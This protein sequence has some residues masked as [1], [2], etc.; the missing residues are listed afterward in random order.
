MQMAK[1]FRQHR[2]RL[3]LRLNTCDILSELWGS[4]TDQKVC[5]RLFA[6][7]NKGFKR[8]KHV[9]KWD[10]SG[11]QV[12]T[13]QVSFSR[14]PKTIFINIL[15]C[16]QTQLHFILWRE[17]NGWAKT[18]S[19]DAVCFSAGVLS[20]HSA[21][22]WSHREKYKTKFMSSFDSSMNEASLIALVW[23]GK[24]I[25]HIL[26]FGGRKFENNKKSRQM[27]AECRI[28]IVDICGW[29]GSSE[30]VSLVIHP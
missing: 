15:I 10:T 23:L 19:T 5:H 6:A 7:S 14:N 1:I 24:Q 27:C 30:W 28:Y 16:H 9:F 20:Y 18:L 11:G 22:Q 8:E 17:K 25:G 21:S 4:T 29:M 12:T 2:L 13:Y 26:I 3:I